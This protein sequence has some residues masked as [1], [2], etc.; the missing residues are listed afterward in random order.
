MQRKCCAV[1]AVIT[2]GTTLLCS[3][4]T[5]AADQ[6][7]TGWT[8]KAELGLVA[9]G[10]NTET[11]TFSFQNTLKR[12]WATSA[13]TLKTAGLRAEQKD[14]TSFYAYGS[15]TTFDTIKKKQTRKTAEAYALEGR[16]DHD[17]TK[18]FFWF[19][20]AGW[21]RNR[22]AGI[23]NR[24]QAVG[25]VGNI[26]FDTDDVK[27]RTDY[28]ASYTDQEDVVED[29]MKDGKYFGARFSWDYENKLTT[30]TTYK[31]ELSANAN[32]ETSSDWRAMML[33]AVSVSIN[34]RLALKVSYTVNYEN[35]P[36]SEDVPLYDTVTQD[37]LI[38]TVPVPLDE[39]DTVLAVSLVV[40]F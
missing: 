18:S 40:N 14:V 38:G 32:L 2:L 1:W 5:R 35:E 15:P 16:Y 24:Y 25:G 37:N 39:F 28:G 36:A 3:V 19:A 30:T 11:T 21:D 4:P 23:E 12:T 8:D 31:N 33:N 22:F 29:P 17:I 26:W 13:F 6:P 7:E 27:F 9:T 20:Q 10:G 34:S